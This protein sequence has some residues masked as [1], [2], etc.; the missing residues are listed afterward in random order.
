MGL[1]IVA[2]HIQTDLRIWVEKEPLKNQAVMTK[3]FGK[4]ELK[5]LEKHQNSVAAICTFD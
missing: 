3:F 1:F 5:F 2:P 4:R